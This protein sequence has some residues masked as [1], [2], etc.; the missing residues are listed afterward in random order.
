MVALLLARQAARQ[1]GAIVIVESDPLFY[2]PAAAGWG[3]DLESLFVIH[4]PQPREQL[5]VLDQCLRCPAVAAV[6]T[7]WEPPHGRDFRR[8]RLAVERGGGLG[9]LVRSGAARKRPSWSDIQFA[10]RPRPGSE[11][12]LGGRRLIVELTRCR[13]GSCGARLELE[14]DEMT[15]GMHAMSSGHEASALHLAAQLAAPASGGGS[16]RA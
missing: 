8:L 4:A 2:P 15:G 12:T 7:V 6:W 3:V 9:V 11:G 1:G 14:L 16:A 10:V 5:W 13:Q